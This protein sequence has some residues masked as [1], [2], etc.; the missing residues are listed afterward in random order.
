MK[1]YDIKITE[2]LEKT[3]TVEANSR[4]EAEAKVEQA[5]NNSEYILDSEDFTGAAFA[6][7]EER[8]PRQKKMDVLLVQPDKHPQAVQIGTDLKFL[9]AA[10]G[11]TIEVTYPFEEPVGIIVNDE[12][13][14]NGMPLN[15]AMRDED[16]EVYDILAGDF[17]V[18]GLTEDSF[19]S[20][21]PE[22]M[23]KYEGFF[24]QPDLFLQM[25]RSIMAIPVPDDIVR[26]RETARE[27]GAK[28]KAT[29]EHSEL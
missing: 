19:C 18:V 14:I 16:G 12:G 5:W 21:T 22:Q 10:V 4:E 17:L 26:A 6:V 3:V 25:G 27:N 20:L 15:R 28:K 23:E 2:T 24:H 29:P 8:S 13:K 1:E 7:Q 11:G 9:Q